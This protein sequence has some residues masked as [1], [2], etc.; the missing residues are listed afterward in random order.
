MS[1]FVP[2]GNRPLPIQPQAAQVPTPTKEVFDDFDGTG[3]TRPQ[4]EKT[5]TWGTNLIG[6]DGFGNI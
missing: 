6:P 4:E 5:G 3:G 1:T 2:N